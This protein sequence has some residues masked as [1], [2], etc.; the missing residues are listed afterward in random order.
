MSE[1]IAAPSST[2]LFMLLTYNNSGN[3]ALGAYTHP[4]GLESEKAQKQLII[5]KQLAYTCYQM[6]GQNI[7][8]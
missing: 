8:A 3:M 1:I 6:Y 7:N 4:D 2:L 5:G